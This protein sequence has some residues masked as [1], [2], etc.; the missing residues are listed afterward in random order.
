MRLTVLP[1][2]VLLL[3]LLLNCSR[4]TSAFAAAS[5]NIQPSMEA[6]PAVTA[7][8]RSIAADLR[9][10]SFEDSESRS[11]TPSWPGNVCGAVDHG[12]RKLVELV[13]MAASS[14][15]SN[16][17][18]STHCQKKHAR[19]L[20]PFSS[21]PLPLCPLPA[22]I[23]KF[24]QFAAEPGMRSVTLQTNNRLFESTIVN[25]LAQQDDGRRFDTKRCDSI[26][27]PAQHAAA[28]HP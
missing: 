28:V 1:H 24:T 18:F 17:A 20:A 7:A 27:N 21:V 26:Q 4:S 8:E 16:Q 9:S 25:D 5:P 3:F 13:F 15:A 14:I 23:K 2:A 19:F 11:A 6:Q 12:R 22:Y 10:W